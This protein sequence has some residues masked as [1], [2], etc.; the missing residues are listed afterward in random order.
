VA[1]IRGVLGSVGGICV[2]VWIEIVAATV[3]CSARHNFEWYSR[4]FWSQKYMPDCRKS[5]LIFQNFLGEAPRPPAGASVFGAR[6]GA[7]PPYRAP[8]SKIPVSAP[9]S[10]TCIQQLN[11]M[12]RNIR[13]SRLINFTAFSTN[14]FILRGMTQKR[15]TVTRI[16]R[17]HRCNT[18]T[19]TYADWDSKD[20]RAYETLIVTVRK[21]SSARGNTTWRRPNS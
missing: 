3:F 19:Y 17:K 16:N 11:W 15:K 18:Q 20:Y 14:E 10:L 4:P 2:C 21:S 12:E 6:F 7:L 9:V 5:H 13:T 8:L 1:E